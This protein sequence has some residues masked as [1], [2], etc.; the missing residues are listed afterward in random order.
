MTLLLSYCATKASSFI[1]VH[2][3]DKMTRQGFE[4]MIIN[5]SVQ[6]PSVDGDEGGDLRSTSRWATNRRA[7]LRYADD[8]ILLT[9]SEAEL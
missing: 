9:T 4:E 8:I 6:H 5:R 7:N 3:R 1:A 2:S